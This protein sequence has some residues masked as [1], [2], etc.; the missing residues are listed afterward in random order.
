MAPLAYLVG[1]SRVKNLTLHKNIIDK[2][3]H[4][5]S[6]PGA[7]YYDLYDLVDNEYISVQRN[8]IHTSTPQLYILAGICNITTVVRGWADGARHEEQIVLLNEAECENTL[9]E[10]KC[11][12]SDLQNFVLRHDTLPVFATIYPSS[13]SEWNLHR[14]NTNKTEVLLHSEEYQP[15]QEKLEAMILDLNNFI[16]ERNLDL[17]V[18]T[19]L[20]HKC[21]WHN[22]GPNRKNKY[23][24]SQLI[25]GI[26]PSFS[27]NKKNS[28]LYGKSISPK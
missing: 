27:L 18:S 22:R 2:F 3:T 26:H 25:D 17:K 19:P 20:T 15:M 21:L 9:R 4:C 23:N 6:K 28:K 7:K 8:I 13:I 5:W 12:I 14:Q 11:A 10:A 24:F 1:D 16:I